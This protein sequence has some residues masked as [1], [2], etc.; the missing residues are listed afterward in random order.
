M[1]RDLVCA[2][3]GGFDLQ[4]GLIIALFLVMI[5]LMYTRRLS[6][7]LAL[8]ILGVGVA[9]IGA[10]P[11]AEA[12]RTLLAE[13]GGLGAAWEM[14]SLKST[15]IDEVIG[16]GSLRLHGAYTIAIIGGMLAIMI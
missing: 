6:A 12:W 8:P 9:L 7:L 2:A 4:G 3:E 11:W 5:A 15:I 13:G 10:I 1:T 14:L 16:Q